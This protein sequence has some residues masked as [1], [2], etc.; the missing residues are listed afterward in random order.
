MITGKDI[1]KIAAV[2]TGA[3][4]LNSTVGR[5][6]Q[7]DFKNKTVL[8]TGGSRGLGLV[9]AREFAR[10]G[11][12]LV[13]CARDEQE[14]EQA[15]LDLENFGVDVMTVP[16]DVT[17]RQSVQQMMAAVTERFGAVDVLVNNAGVIQVGPIEVMAAE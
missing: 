12:R 4:L 1:I 3:V 16:C 17:D 9:L 13:I 15:R 2:A 5:L 8:I 7:Y 11:A 6:R 14:L 10:E